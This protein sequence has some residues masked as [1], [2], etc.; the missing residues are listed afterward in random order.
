MI[1]ALARQAIA[2]D[3]SD[4]EARWCLGGAL[5]RVGDYKGALA[6]AQR[7]L[8]I[9][10]NLTSAHDL[11]GATLIVSGQPKEGLAALETLIRLDPRHPN[12]ASHLMRT[13]M[14]L[15]F[16]R[17][18]ERSAE[19]AQA[20]IRLFPDFPN[21]YRWLAAALGQLGRSEEAKEALEKAV[22]VSPASFDTFVRHRVPWHRPEDHAHMVEGLLKAG[23]SEE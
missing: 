9:N 2:L 1:L 5:R 12:L 3:P 18:Y 11:L 21:N 6:E 16:L 15:Y 14:G 8:T 22:A 19:A 10:P 23:L 4:A 20:G 17:D 7:A 13:A